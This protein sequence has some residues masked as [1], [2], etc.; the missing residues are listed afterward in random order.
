MAECS[1]SAVRSRRQRL[2]ERI[3]AALD[4]DTGRTEAQL[5]WVQYAGEH[6]ALRVGL[7]LNSP[8]WRRHVRAR[9]LQRI[10][11]GPG[12]LRWLPCDRS[13]RAQGWL[14]PENLDCPAGHGTLGAVLRSRRD[15][16]TL[17]AVTAGHVVA[18]DPAARWGNR[19]RLA[20]VFPPLQVEGRL[21]N[22]SPDLGRRDRDARFD[23]ALVAL[24][25]AALEPLVNTI[26]WP[27][28]WADAAPGT[29]AYLLT[30]H[31]HL[32]AKITG[33]ISAIVEAGDPPQRYA[34][35]DV[36]CYQVD[37]GTQGGDSGAALWDEAERLVGLHVGEAPEGSAG[38]ALASPI[39]RV[40]DWSGCD[41]MLRNQPLQDEARI[42]P[43]PPPA[44]P[45]PVA[46]GASESLAAV[47]TLARTIWG[48]ARGEPDAQAGMRAVA[49]V[50]LNRRDAPG[51]W[52][53]SVAGVCLKPWQFSCWNE[54]DPNRPKMLAVGAGDASFTLARRIAA[55]LVGLN[56]TE[57]ARADTTGGA[58][59]YF[60]ASIA[61]P[62]WTVRASFCGRIGNHLFY[63][64]VA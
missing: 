7:H 31:H 49:H 1:A 43:R 51:W 20:Q 18:A 60:A 41:L 59:H 27:L 56:P 63:R 50:V 21:A 5:R 8:L 47:D 46:S 11:A 2:Y 32:P 36:L 44:S 15:D 42:A 62:P 24:D 30:R 10:G 35:Q 6:T 54:G 22:W 28:G 13:P 52:G 23:A 64:D 33:R 14:R 17:Y 38:N 61:P 39:G 12:D 40:L 45:D 53:R 55:D 19:V 29:V 57:R 58:T 4:A 3:C 16:A 9:W 26:E 34:L 37:S 25:V 48:E